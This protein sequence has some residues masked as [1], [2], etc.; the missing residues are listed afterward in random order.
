M[1]IRLLYLT[2]IFLPLDS[3]V[4]KPVTL[5]KVVPGQEVDTPI[6]DTYAQIIAKYDDR[7]KN[8]IQFLERFA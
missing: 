3:F 6:W 7:G 4:E 5:M 1:A 2:E 8:A